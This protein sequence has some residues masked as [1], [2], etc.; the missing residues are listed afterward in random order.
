MAFIPTLNILSALNTAI[1][2]LKLADGTTAA[3]DKVAYYDKPDLTRA[4]AEL[5][6]FANRI[7]L[8]V[9][10]G[11]R[12][13][14]QVDGRFAIVQAHRTVILLLAD[15]QPAVRQAASTGDTNTPGVVKL[16]QIVVDALCGV[17]LG[18]GAVRVLPQHGEPVMI[19][20]AARKD[21]P[22]REAW[23]IE[24]SI[25]AGRA[26]TYTNPRTA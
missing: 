16:N 11:D 22:G 20:D 4:L 26:K 2:A 13:E 5:R 6:I 1:A 7:C 25:A 14:S 3:F 10:D 8:I 23:T 15:R 9:P 24:L 19:S 18:I 17:D 12:Y 21:L